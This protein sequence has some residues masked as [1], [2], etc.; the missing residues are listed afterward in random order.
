M[1]F[2]LN[3]PLRE[4]IALYDVDV[5][6]WR[7]SRDEVR[8]LAGVLSTRPVIAVDVLVHDSVSVEQRRELSQ[9]LCQKPDVLEMIRTRAE[10][11]WQGGVFDIAA[12]WSG[13]RPPLWQHTAVAPV[14]VAASA[15]L[16]D[17]AWDAL[18]EE[19]AERRVI[20]VLIGL[21]SSVTPPRDGA[22]LRYVFSWP[23]ECPCPLHAPRELAKVLTD[24]CI[25]KETGRV[26]KTSLEAIKADRDAK[27]STVRSLE[28]Q[29]ELSQQLAANRDR[30]RKDAPRLL[31]EWKT[32]KVGEVS[33][34][35]K[36][37][38]DRTD[39]KSRLVQKARVIEESLL[40]LKIEPFDS[41]NDAGRLP[42]GFEERA[43]A[44]F[45]QVVEE[46]LQEIERQLQQTYEAVTKDV[47]RVLAVAGI[48]VTPPALQ[49]AA[50]GSR[51]NGGVRLQPKTVEEPIPKPAAGFL[52]QSRAKLSVVGSV[53]MVLALASGG[54][55][56]RGDLFKLLQV[57]YLGW[58][59][60]ILLLCWTVNDARSLRRDRE[61]EALR[62]ARASIRTAFETEMQ[63]LGA[64]TQ[65]DIQIATD[66]AIEAIKWSID[67]VAEQ[68]RVSDTR[69]ENALRASLLAVN[70]SL[71]NQSM[72]NDLIKLRTR[73]ADHEATQR[74]TLRTQVQEPV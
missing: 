35:I 71:N 6:V 20:T 18:V 23:L 17:T 15:S 50:R 28:A 7:G 52:S 56:G 66:Q 36:A 26:V 72:Q 70:S 31:V 9:W 53:F 63:R 64:E 38:F 54:A 12:N 8:A 2:S 33:V 58:I 62:K 40:T 46:R 32:K 61:K 22:G 34:L 43:A 74:V 65:S 48:K 69:R 14:L 67:N 5:E 3:D 57:Y 37:A 39:Q 44:D 73:I 29:L 13:D 68:E 49:L 16:A 59:L 42:D 45:G 11:A 21:S 30:A 10:V 51:T 47:D 1:P 4:L 19:E 27:M 60:V 24:V 41:G 25:A 55:L